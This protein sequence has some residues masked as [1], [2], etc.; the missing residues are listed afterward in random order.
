MEKGS[1]E[2]KI[3]EGMFESFRT[4]P[5]PLKEL[6]VFAQSLALSYLALIRNRNPNAFSETQLQPM[7]DMIR[8]GVKVDWLIA[9]FDQAA[10]LASELL[11][12]QKIT[13]SFATIISKMA[14]AQANMQS[15]RLIPLASR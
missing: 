5:I 15:Q 1:L 14:A 2:E 12:D 7:S 10:V 13:V 9:A 8:Q 11:K 4:A 3:S 6:H